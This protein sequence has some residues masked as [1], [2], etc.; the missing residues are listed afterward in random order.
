[1]NNPTKETKKSRKERAEAEFG[2]MNGPPIVC[3]YM[4]RFPQVLDIIAVVPTMHTKIHLCAYVVT[5]CLHKLKVDDAPGF[6]TM[7]RRL[8][9]HRDSLEHGT[10]CTNATGLFVLAKRYV[11]MINFTSN[12]CVVGF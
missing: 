3:K 5:P 12:L 1:M 10:L 8:E 7:L 6:K 4:K 11:A 9:V 2:D